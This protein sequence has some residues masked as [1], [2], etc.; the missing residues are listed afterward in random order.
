MHPLL[1]I[2]LIFVVFGLI[3]RVYPSKTKREI[4]KKMGIG[5]VLIAPPNVDVESRLKVILSLA[6]NPN[7]IRLYV[8]KIC[9]G[10]E[11]PVEMSN[12]KTRVATRMHFVRARNNTE[13]CLRAALIQKVLEPHILCIPWYHEVE[14]AWDELLL[15]ELVACHDS[16]AVLTTHLSNRAEQPKFM[17]V[18][19]LDGEIIS[20]D[21][22]QFASPP[23]RPELS[24]LCSAQ[25]LFGPTSLLQTGWPS[26]QELREVH[27][28]STLTA[29]LWMSGAC[30]YSPHNQPVFS[31]V[32]REV[33]DVPGRVGTPKKTSTR[34]Q[35][36]FWMSI[37]IRRGR[38]SSRARCGLTLKA[39][40][41]ERFH[42]IGQTIA[43]E[44]EI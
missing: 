7:M 25:L 15:K 38:L 4:S 22:T 23:V 1:I 21:S 28:D 26:K 6:S 29:F 20:F 41:N 3:Q 42:K 24:L 10:G 43:L 12:L 30:F 34:T 16:S 32:G 9:D 39:S 19:S 18:S 8:V 44:R 31:E 36:E 11:I 37:G 2:V 13:S 33:K 35:D 17:F 40:V 27:E 5:V 14:W